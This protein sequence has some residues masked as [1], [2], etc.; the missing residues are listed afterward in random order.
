VHSVTVRSITLL[1]RNQ[2][3]LRSIKKVKKEEELDPI[4]VAAVEAKLQALDLDTDAPLSGP[5]AVQV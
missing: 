2:L 4:L 5:E 1:N 3:T